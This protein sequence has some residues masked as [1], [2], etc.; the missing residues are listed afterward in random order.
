[1]HKKESLQ[2]NE[3]HRILLDF[4]IQMDCLIPTRRQE[5]VLITKKKRTCYLADFAISAD[6]RGKKKKATEKIKKYL[7]LA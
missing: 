1:M 6:H 3:T 7:D 5:L 2:G 4:E